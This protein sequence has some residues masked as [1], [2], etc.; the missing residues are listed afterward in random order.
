MSSEDLNLLSQ[1]VAGYTNPDQKIRSESE[2]FISDFRNKSMGAICSCLL[3]VTSLENISSTIKLTSLVLL[4]K[5]IS[6]DSKDK[7][8]DIDEETKNSIKTL[9]L[10]LFLKEKDQNIKNK[11]CDVITELV[12]NIAD[13]N[14][15]WPELVT[16]SYS[17]NSYN[18][19]DP[20][21]TLLIDSIVKMIT[22]SV[23]FLYE[24][25]TQKYQEFLMFFDNIFNNCKIIQL[26][27]RTSKFI[28]DLLTFGDRN[29]KD[30]LKPYIF[31]ILE[32][33]LFCFTTN[34]EN[35][36][37]SMLNTIIE[38]ASFQSKILNK[39]FAD[40]VILS[41]KICGKTDYSVQNSQKIRELSFEIVISI[42]ESIPSL[43]T[44]DP[45]KLKMYLNQLYYYA[46]E[47]TE[48]SDN[49]DWCFPSVNSFSDLPTI[50]E[51]NVR[52]V[53]SVIDRI[54]SAI[55]PDK[56]ISIL[57]DVITSLFSKDN[58]QCKY[59]G[60]ISLSQVICYSDSMESV[61]NIIPFVFSMIKHSAP[62]VRFA[63]LNC[64]DE[65]ATSFQNEFQNKY[66]S[67][68]IPL[69]L[70]AL[71]SETIARVQCECVTSLISIIAYSPENDIFMP[72]IQ[73]CIETLMKVFQKE[74]TYNLTKK[75]ILI[76]IAEIV[77]KI[78]EDCKTFSKNLMGLL[79]KYLN[80]Y[81]MKK[82]NL[83]LIPNLIYT[84]TLLGIN[85]LEELVPIIPSLIKC[86]IELIDS[87]KSNINPM[88]AEIQTTLEHLIPSI[89]KHYPQYI[90]VLVQTLFKLLTL[91]N[92]S[93]NIN[94]ENNSSSTAEID[95]V[96]DCV[97]LL[98]TVIENLEEQ[99]FQ[100][101]LP[102]E[103]IVMKML[104]ET[105]NNK[106][107]KALIRVLGSL[108]SVLYLKKEV[109]VLKEKSK[110]YISIILTFT[111]KE[112]ENKVC[113]TLIEALNK[114]IDN[115]VD[116]L[117]QGDLEKLF[118]EILTILSS[119]EER[120]VQVVK[121][122]TKNDNEYEEENDNKED[123]KDSNDDEEEKQKNNNYLHHIFREDITD[124]EDIEEKL[125]E[126]IECILKG[127]KGGQ[128]QKFENILKILID[129]TIPVFLN[130]ENQTPLLINYPNNFKLAA[131]AIDIIIENFEFNFNSNI[132]Q[133]LITNLIHLSSHQEPSIRQPAVYGLGLILK[134]CSID[135]YNQYSSV[136]YEKLKTAI[137]LFTN[138]KRDEGLAYDN[139]VASIGKGIGYKNFNNKDFIML[140]L[141]NLPI[142][143][144][145]SEK[146]EQNEILCNFILM[147]KYMN[148]LDI[149]QLSFVIDV[150]VKVYGSIDQSNSTINHSIIEIFKKSKES[151]GPLREAMEL[152][153]KSN[154]NIRNKMEEITKKI[155]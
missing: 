100:F 85:E 84:I 94:E 101:F 104:H 65:L 123:D 89:Q 29:E 74:D 126:T 27:V 14:E 155:K 17:I 119:F 147:E 3:K 52:F 43:F 63:A 125:I 87:L 35:N 71:S 122:I 50:G 51:D 131:L 6:V 107:K 69:I 61:E 128:N 99:Y 97:N 30:N 11:Y 108:I 109:N 83:I 75:E 110:E 148:I 22:D 26:K 72:F 103:Q 18:V 150:L 106:L 88:R 46:L 116:S 58:N 64:V 21:N 138:K 112:Y 90:P 95:D 53:H 37:I 47:T 92:G 1:I 19:N 8:G 152:V 144:D 36:L 133:F 114:I 77:N 57:S 102:T 48:N 20:E 62:K 130:S 66:C 9:V 151:N 143:F 135:V 13:F 154:D 137:T 31:N 33:T 118:K 129:S 113:A 15:K 60:L 93:P 141:K 12:D 79:M 115:S 91:S 127:N 149:N 44:K 86:E 67:Q 68:I 121:N 98:N 38:I 73:N 41:C 117:E 28:S 2:K 7:W 54:N 70:E 40:I 10:E 82:I 34:D 132:I 145:S 59:V 111:G 16:L 124:I 105:K 25:I 96:V 120:R 140:W 139:A 49:K 136:I 55:N 42:I 80:E 45:E 153:Y 24:D 76:C 146:K 23:G 39:Y 32:T 4:R 81:Y 56:F 78:N 134:K 142:K 5:I